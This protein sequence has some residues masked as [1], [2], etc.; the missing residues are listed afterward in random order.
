MDLKS[1]LPK[2][3]EEE[4]YF[5]SLAIEP[6]W[7]SAGIWKLTENK[8]QVI[9]VSPS[10]SWHLDD[11]LVSACDASCSSVVQNFPE[12]ID[13]PSKTVFGVVS[14]WVEDGEIKA[15]YLSKIKRVC[16]ELSLEPVGFVVM[17]EALCNYFKAEE[18]GLV[19]A[20]FLGVFQDN[21]ELSIFRLGK[22]VGVSQIARSV[23]V[24]EDVSEGLSRFKSDEAYP[25]RIILY[26]SK[27]G[28]L[29]EIR[30]ELIKADWENYK[31]I[32]FL[33]TPKIEIVPSDK[34]VHAVCLAGGA[35]MGNVEQIDTSSDLP[36]EPGMENVAADDK[37]DAQSNDTIR[38][39]TSNLTE[40][41]SDISP[42]DFG[43]TVNKED[44][45]GN[46]VAIASKFVEQKNAPQEEAQMPA[47]PQKKTFTDKLGRIS[48][49]FSFFKRFQRH[50][51][52]ISESSV[53]MRLPTPKPLI[54]GFLILFLVTVGL[55]VF[56]WFFPKAE[57]SIY[58][59][60]KNIQED[61]EIRVDSSASSS[62][63][64]D[65]L[66]A[67]GVVDESLSEDK[68]VSTTGTKVVGDKA[69][70]EVTIYRSGS[71][72]KL[73]KDTLI[74]GPGSLN[75][76]LDEEINVASGSVLT[77]GVTKAKVTA[78]EIGAQYNLAAGST[79]TVANYSNADMEATNE[80]A[81]SGGTSRE[82]NAVSEADQKKLFDDL[83]SEIQSNLKEK[84][85]GKI[86]DS[87]VLIADSITYSL[88]NKEFDKKVGDEGTTLSLSLELKADGVTVNKNDIEKLG[89]KYLSQRVPTGYSLKNNQIESD[90]TYQTKEDSVYN[91]KLIVSANLL[92]QVDIDKIRKN[93]T[94]KFPNTAEEYLKN[95][96]PGYE[97]VVIKFLNINLPGRL[98]TL[99]RVP[100][101]I[102][103][104]VSA[105]K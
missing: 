16:S 66:L 2:R 15:E 9:S 88:T 49:L 105:D 18:G 5:W 97:R 19:N 45:L 25:S 101:N 64:D 39:E 14:S 82:V 70:G 84:L 103:I 99:P 21:L 56:W 6:E 67:G 62:D 47:S 80:S 48:N 78:K 41:D 31:D 94:G 23:S 93:I 102:E 46:E 29:D 98:G 36:V 57:V 44:A 95:N 42:E 69:S 74:K 35:E 83:Q 68:S 27:E 54:V 50:S 43:F 61:V 96:V 90:F 87:Q 30:Q 76:S 104:S 13:P 79:F 91:L 10:S 72:L 86:P 28:E 12:E 51:E 71:S 32:K 40:P 75:F 17:S 65:L 52:N 85:S 24:V 89:L 11:E 7:V 1:V 22:L 100:G 73:D 81:F 58:V 3:K 59:S 4:R 26:N 77:R 38:H 53:T 20:V 37:L 8:V 34:K 63:F 92:P 33:H 60:P 55:F